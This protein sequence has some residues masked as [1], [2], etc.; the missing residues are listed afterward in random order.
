M[1]PRQIAEADG[2]ARDLVVEAQGDEPAGGH[3]DRRG[4]GR[5]DALQRVRL[6]GDGHAR[7]L[8][9]AGLAPPGPAAADAA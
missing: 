9:S 2:H 5:G 1:L 6:E 7:N 8:S 4:D 3:H